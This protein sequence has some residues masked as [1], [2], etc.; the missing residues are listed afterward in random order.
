MATT[1]GTEPAKKGRA[2]K[3]EGPYTIS[4]VDTDNKDTARIPAS[5]HAVKIADKSGKSKA[6]AVSSL[7]PKVLHQLAALGL[8]RKLDAFM[9]NSI[10]GDKTAIVLADEM[11]ANVK[12]GKLYLKGE[13]K[14]GA[15]RSFDFD[16]WVSAIQR[17]AEL[18]NKAD[19]KKQ[20]PATK[21]QLDSV[22]VKL[23]SADSAGRKALIDR[24]KK[25]PVFVLAKKQVDAERATKNAGETKAGDVNALADLF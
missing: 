5:V 22:R 11:Y 25:D 1:N 10:G 20:K 15:G 4:F 8:G 16:L 2:K 9:R 19:P 24:W 17:T 7:E 21:A 23:E 13:G 3:G 12:S 6:Y 18:H 14:G